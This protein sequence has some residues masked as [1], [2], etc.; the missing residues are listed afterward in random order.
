MHITITNYKIALVIIKRKLEDDNL[1]T[2]FHNFENFLFKVLEWRILGYTLRL[3]RN[4]IRFRHFYVFLW[5][6]Y[7]LF[8]TCLK[9]KLHQQNWKMQQFFKEDKNLLM[10]EI[11]NQNI[12]TV[13][14]N[15]ITVG[16]G[17]HPLWFFLNNFKTA[18]FFNFK[19]C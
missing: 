2:M 7:F 18:N 16:G 3:T 9:Q 11:W 10:Q 15:P 19:F 1:S 5:N 4:F 14:L 8:K 17:P 12:Y 6:I 13:L